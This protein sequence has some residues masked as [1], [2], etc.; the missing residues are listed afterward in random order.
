VKE[1]HEADKIPSILVDEVPLVKEEEEEEKE[2]VEMDNNKKLVLSKPSNRRGI[3]FVFIMLI[4]ITSP[5]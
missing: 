5:S 3:I 1:E 4:F 2:V